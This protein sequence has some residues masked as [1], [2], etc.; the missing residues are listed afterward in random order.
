MRRRRV[1]RLILVLLVLAVVVWVEPTR[2]LIGLLRLEHFYAGRPT[3]YWS[4]Q[5]RAASAPLPW[6][7]RM[8]IHI[9]LGNWRSEPDLRILKDRGRATIPVLLELLDDPDLAVRGKA[10][11]VLVQMQDASPWEILPAILVQFRQVPAPRHRAASIVQRMGE[12]GV[13]FFER[14]RHDE[15]PDVRAGA[16][17]ALI[18]MH[19]VLPK[20]VLPELRQA[21]RGSLNFG[22]AAG[23]VIAMGPEAAAAVPELIDALAMPPGLHNANLRELALVVLTSIGEPAVPALVEALERW[24]HG[25]RPFHPVKPSDV[26]AALGRIGLPAKPALPALRKASRSAD[27]ELRVAAAEAIKRITEAPSVASPH[28]E[29][30]PM[31]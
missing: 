25:G 12:D 14:L 5:I 29:G 7:N 6:T 18:E 24:P 1:I 4:R 10:A 23:V 31:P 30:Q 3:S 9:G 8:L 26:A 2:V 19:A 22:A 17:L 11:Y 16:A 28:R 20:D 13:A 21:L 15:D 27:R